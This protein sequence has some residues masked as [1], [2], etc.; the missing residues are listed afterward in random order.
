MFVKAGQSQRQ[1]RLSRPDTLN[2]HT[3]TETETLPPRPAP[4]SSQRGCPC[5]HTSGT[6]TFAT[7]A[8]PLRGRDLRLAHLGPALSPGARSP[9]PV[10]ISSS[11][12]LTDTD[13]LAA[14]PIPDQN[15]PQRPLFLHHKLLSSD[16]PNRQ[17]GLLLLSLGSC[18]RHLTAPHE[19]LQTFLPDIG[20]SE[21]P[22]ASPTGTRGSFFF[23]SLEI[24]PSLGA[25]NPVT[26]LY[27][28]PTPARPERPMGKPHGEALRTQPAV[29]TSHQISGDSLDVASSR[30]PLASL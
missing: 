24:G 30:S 1:G 18:L 12:D 5:G 3:S 23:N 15:K 4:T 16:I 6:N 13:A 20:S 17:P 29:S 21:N 7:H 19:P 2:A 25:R 8:P 9:A 11:R 28:K 10:E 22:L 27:K 14:L 26:V